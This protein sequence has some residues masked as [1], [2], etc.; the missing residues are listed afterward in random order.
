MS[1]FHSQR[2]V[3]ICGSKIRPNFLKDQAS[4]KTGSYKKR[5]I[6]TLKPLEK[7][8]IRNGKL[9]LKSAELRVNLLRVSVK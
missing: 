6:K 9:P 4:K 8:S 7:L 1:E 2:G 3:K 5:L